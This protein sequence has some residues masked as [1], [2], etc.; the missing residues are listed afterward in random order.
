M[1]VVPVVWLKLSSAWDLTFESPRVM[2]HV[3]LISNRCSYGFAG[4]SGM[5]CM[6]CTVGLHCV[7]TE[8]PSVIMRSLA[9]FAAV[10]TR[11]CETS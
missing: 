2:H 9:N 7:H 5:W 6:V 1:S 3:V 4:W 8:T 10:V 11:N